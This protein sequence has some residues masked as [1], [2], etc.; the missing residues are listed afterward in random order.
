MNIILHKAS[1]ISGGVQV[2]LMAIVCN[3]HG[4]KKILRTEALSK[5]SVSSL[6]LASMSGEIPLE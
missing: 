1:T 4:T 3:T 6:P 2:S 5:S